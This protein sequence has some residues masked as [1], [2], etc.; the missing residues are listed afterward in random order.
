MR[1]RRSE[2]L[3]ERRDAETRRKKEEEAEKRSGVCGVGSDGFFE[4][5]CAWISLF[6]LIS[7]S[8]RLGVHV[9]IDSCDRAARKDWWNAETPRRGGRKRRRRRREVG[10]VE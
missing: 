7:A 1:P 10:C 6:C 4:S 5:D 3:V 9:G 8:W 2:R